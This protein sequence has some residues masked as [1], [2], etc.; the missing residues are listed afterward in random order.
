MLASSKAA[1]KGKPASSSD[2]PGKMSNADGDKNQQKYV[3]T[4]VN[5]NG[6]EVNNILN[7]AVIHIISFLIGFL[8]LTA[9]SKACR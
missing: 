6:K 9:Y 1:A 5:V 4:T 3:A 2:T 8:C 7:V